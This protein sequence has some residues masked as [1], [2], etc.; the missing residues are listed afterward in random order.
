M[1]TT[2]PTATETLTPTPTGHLWPDPDA[3]APV[4]DGAGTGLPGRQQQRPL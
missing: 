4:G 3:H 1:P 2:T